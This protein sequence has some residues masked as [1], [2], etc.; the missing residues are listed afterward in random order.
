MGE[1]PRGADAGGLISIR[2]LAMSAAMASTSA[3]VAADLLLGGGLLGSG[4]LIPGVW[5]LRS[6]TPRQ[7]A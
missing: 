7:G 6:R 2:V 3:G 1:H 5:L 4:S